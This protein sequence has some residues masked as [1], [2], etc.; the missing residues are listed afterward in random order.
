LTFTG[1][2]IRGKAKEYSLYNQQKRSK[3]VV[4]ARISVTIADGMPKA[5]IHRH[6]SWWTW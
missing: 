3:Q 6:F 4:D 1:Y 2:S 5:T